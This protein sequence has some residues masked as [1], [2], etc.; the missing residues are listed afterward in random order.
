MSHEIRTPLTAIIGFTG[1]LADRDDLPETAKTMVSR[2]AG[3]GSALLNIVNDILDFSKLEAGQVSIDPR[4]VDVTRLARDALAMF[5]VQAQAKSLTTRFS[6]AADIPP[7][8]RLDPRHLQQLLFNLLGNAFKFTEVGEVA[9]RLDF[10]AADE[11]LWVRVEDTGPGMDESQRAHV[12]QRFSQV[13]ASSTRRHGGTGLGLAICKGLAEAMGGGVSVES[14]PGR[15]SAFTFHVTAPPAAE[16][17]Q[18]EAE[19]EPGATLKDIRV[20]VAD[21]KAANLELARALLEHFKAEVTEAVDGLEAVRRA[22]EEPFDVILLDLHMPGLDGYGALAR[23]R[24]EPGPNQHVPIFAFTADG[25]DTVDCPRHGFDGVIEKP[26]S[27]AALVSA[28]IQATD[29]REPE[30][31]AEAGYAARG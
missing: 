1:L 11:T 15:G 21:D 6:A 8:V 4:P 26:I 20:L 23:I 19:D 30:D 12:F 14:T 25:K 18:A 13:D 17:A 9:V 27:A 5:A 29:W 2:V 3:A 24:H 22:S 16:P 7:R 28:L 10:D 31:E